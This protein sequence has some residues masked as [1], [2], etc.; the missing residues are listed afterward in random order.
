M[1]TPPPFS[2]RPLDPVFGPQAVALAR[3]VGVPGIYVQNHLLADPD[4]GGRAEILALHGREDLLG[5]VYCGDRGNLIVLTTEDLD[6]EILARAV[7]D[8]SLRWR[9]VLG[10]H[11][12][13]AALRRLNDAPPLVHRTQIY[14]AVA[15]AA[16]PVERLRD[17]VRRAQRQDA[18]ALVLATLHLNETDLGVDAWRVNKDW[19]RKNVRLRIREGSTLVIGPVGNPWVKLDIGSKGPAGL[20]LEG[21]YTWPEFRGQGHAASLVATVA[22]RAGEDC[23]VV[24]LHVAEDNQPARRAYENAGMRE[25]DRC[26]LLLKS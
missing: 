23:P 17:D 18:K 9:I 2:A 19:V 14:Y 11:D 13:V 16:V 5:L 21:V 25:V 4:L 10:P 3:R 15:P 6:P 1:Q 20:I 8:S 22:Q 12:L 7:I 26:G 24:C